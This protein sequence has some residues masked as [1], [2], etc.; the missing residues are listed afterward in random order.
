MPAHNKIPYIGSVD[1]VDCNSGSCSD[2]GVCNEE[3]GGGVICECSHGYTGDDCGT[4][5]DDC[6][7]NP[8]VLYISLDRRYM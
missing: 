6:S 7:P 8:C 2:N 1:V 4:N 3:V 5:I